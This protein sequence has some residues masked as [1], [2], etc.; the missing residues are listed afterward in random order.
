MPTRTTCSA[1]SCSHRAKTR[2]PSSSFSSPCAS[3]PTTPTSTTSS[4]RPTRNQDSPTSLNSTST[5]S[6]NSRTK[7]AE[8]AR[9]EDQLDTELRLSRITRP[10]GLAE[11]ACRLETGDP[12]RRLRAVRIEAGADR[13]Q[14]RADVHEVDPIEDIENLEPELGLHPLGDLDVLV[15]R[16]I[17]LEEIWPFA[18]TAPGISEAAQLEAHERPCARVEDLLLR[19]AGGVAGLA[20]HD[21]RPLIVLET[22]AGDAVRQ[23]WHAA[24]GDGDGA[25]RR[26]LDDRSDLPAAEDMLFEP[27]FVLELGQHQDQAGVEDVLPVGLGQ[28]AVEVPVLQDADALFGKAVLASGEGHV[29]DRTRPRV[30]SLELGA[31]PEAAHDLRLERVVDGAAAVVEDRD[32]LVAEH[33][34]GTLRG[35]GVAVGAGVDVVQ[36]VGR[37]H[38]VGIVGAEEAGAL[39]AHVA[40]LDGR[41]VCDLFLHARVPLPVVAELPACIEPVLG[42]ALVR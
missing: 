22:R 10:S 8:T 26:R 34:V 6:E 41:V 24:R 29:A 7:N 12:G 3:P 16:Q 5:P 38:L 30:R 18:H 25:A 1:R 23:V 13:V 32:A 11:V 33:A 9:S 40:D 27:R 39:A 17:D 28:A 35:Q 2:P 36:A 20:F 21:V 19:T 14:A 42:D 4:D 15:E 31:V 37:W